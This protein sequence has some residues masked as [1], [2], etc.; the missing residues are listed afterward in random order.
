M[1]PK[2]VNMKFLYHTS[3]GR[4][5]NVPT[6]RV[7][8][9]M[10]QG[11]ILRLLKPVDGTLMNCEQEVMLGPSKKAMMAFSEDFGLF[12]YFLLD[13]GAMELKIFNIEDN[14]PFTLMNK[15]KNN[16]SIDV[17]FE[18]RLTQDDL[19]FIKTIKFDAQNRF[20][21]GF[22]D[23]KIFIFNV[24]TFE[25]KFYTIDGL[26]FERILDI[27]M[28]SESGLTYQIQVAC[29]RVGLKQIQIFD[30]LEFERI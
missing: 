3:D 11:V 17:L 24:D 9:G 30:I 20:L 18:N 2:E 5:M 26:Y 16:H 13:P 6:D 4:M 1:L 14:S 21:L 23:V 28:R 12:A 7:Y 29:K 27:Q 10:Q 8:N 22:G 15:I 25:H 19:R